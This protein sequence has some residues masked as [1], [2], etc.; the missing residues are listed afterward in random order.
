MAFFLPNL[1]H[2]V[3]LRCFGLSSRVLTRAQD[4]CLISHSTSAALFAFAFAFAH[5]LSAYIQDHTLTWDRLMSDYEV[6]LVN[7]NSMCIPSK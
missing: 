1:G 7:D 3:S 4:V 2:E 6:T 5:R